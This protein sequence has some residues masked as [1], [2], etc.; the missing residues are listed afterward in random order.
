MIKLV[1]T[2]AEIERCFPVVYELRPHIQPETFSSHIKAL[3]ED[4]YQMA[5]KA[6]DAQIV[7]VAGFRISHNLFAGKHLYVDDL[8]TLE[9]ERSKGYG[10][11]MMNWL[12]DLAIVSE[13]N[14]FHLDSGVQRHKAHKFY[15]N[16]GMDIVCYH[17][18]QKL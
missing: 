16:Q 9:P 15:L 11:E 14:A 2:D 17:F 8:V 12:R 1:E 5:F 13:C 18:L 3:M 4:G 6:V 10:E 7:C